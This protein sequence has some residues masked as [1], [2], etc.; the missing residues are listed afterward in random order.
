MMEQGLK[1]LH[2]EAEESDK[3][4]LRR[5]E[6]ESSKD[7]DST[8]RDGSYK[9]DE[10]RQDAKTEDISAIKELEEDVGDTKTESMVDTKKE[11]VSITIDDDQKL[12]K[13]DVTEEEADSGLAVAQEN[14]HSISKKPAP[15]STKSSSDSLTVESEVRPARRGRGRRRRRRNDNRTNKTNQADISAREIKRVVT[16]SE[17]STSSSQ[18]SDDEIFQMEDFCEEDEEKMPQPQPVK[19]DRSSFG[20][21]RGVEEVTPEEWKGLLHVAPHRDFHPLSDGD[22][23]P[24]LR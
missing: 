5:S 4:H 16:V 23:T 18:H 20:G 1:K 15:L 11:S 10:D 12:P 24:L 8:P 17:S 7:S 2:A 13:N 21:F 19:Q 22:C 14:A 6:T 3:R 9:G